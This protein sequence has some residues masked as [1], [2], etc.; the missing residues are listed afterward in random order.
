MHTT[1]QYRALVMSALF[2]VA[3]LAPGTTSAQM[4]GWEVGG[5]VGA[6]NYFGDLNTDW[7]VNRLQPAGMIGARYNFNDRLSTRIGFSVGQVSAFDSDSK[8]IYEQTRNLHFKSMIFDAT[9]Q[10]EFNFLPYVHGHRDYYYTP[11]MFLGPSLFRY[12]PRAELNGTWYDLVDY[13]TEGQFLGEEYN[14]IQGGIAYG[15]G[16]RYDL[17]YRWSLNIE[18]SARK[19]FTDYLDDVSG[20]YADPRDIR[21][22]RG[23]LAVQL[24]D[25]SEEPKIGLQGRQ[26]G[27]GRNNDAYMFLTVGAMYYFGQIR[28]PQMRD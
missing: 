5:M 16:F 15:M 4:K 28:C 24:A 2:F 22:Q 23:D 17:S 12:N 7:R 9:A 27:N 6:A 1:S 11:Y 26:R 14:T 25:R 18:F 8:N 20:T 21:S 3:M 13:G 10:F 19:L